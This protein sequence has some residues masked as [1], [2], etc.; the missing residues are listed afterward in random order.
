QKHREFSS[1]IG[2]EIAVE[3]IAPEKIEHALA[4]SKEIDD[5]EA[6]STALFDP[7]VFEVRRRVY[8]SFME[9]FSDSEMV[10]LFTLFELGSMNYYSESFDYL[11]NKYT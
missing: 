1:L 2:V 8:E 5:S 6:N 9:N 3:T 4:L 10:T 11:F 7:E